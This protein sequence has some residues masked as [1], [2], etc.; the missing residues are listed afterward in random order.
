MT[1]NGG[2]SPTDPIVSV[3]QAV[4]GGGTPA[5]TVDVPVAQPGNKLRWAPDF[6]SFLDEN[7]PADAFWQDAVAP[8]AWNNDGTAA[9]WYTRPAYDPMDPFGNGAPAAQRYYAFDDAMNEGAWGPEHTGRDMPT[10][11]ELQAAGLT[12]WA[13][14][15][16]RAHLAARVGDGSDPF[17]DPAAMAKALMGL[18]SEEDPTGIGYG[19]NPFGP[20]QSGLSTGAYMAQQKSNFAYDQLME[21]GAPEEYAAAMRDAIKDYE[22]QYEKQRKEAEGDMFEPKEMFKDALGSFGQILSLPPIQAMLAAMTLGG[23]SVLAEGAKAGATAATDA[24]AASSLAAGVAPEV[25]A[26]F[27]G[28]DTAA[29][30]GADLAGAGMLGAGGAAAAPVVAGGGEVLNLFGPTSYMNQPSFLAAG[31]GEAALGA[32]GVLPP[33]A[34]VPGDVLG[35]MIKLQEVTGTSSFNEAA[36]VL[37]FDSADALMQS[38]P[39][40]APEAFSAGAAATAEPGMFDQIEK[41]Y[42]QVKP[43][44]DQYKEL[45]QTVDSLT[46]GQPADAPVR[47]EGMSDDQ[48]AAE[49]ILYMGLSPED[50]LAAGYEPGTREYNEYVLQQADRVIM[51]IMGE[52]GNTADAEQMSAALRAKSE[53]ELM[54]LQRALYVR[55]AMGQMM[56]SGKYVDPLSGNEQEVLGSGQFNPGL[57]AYGQGF[58]GDIE[59]L[60]QMGMTDA[61]GAEQFLRSILGRK[62]DMF[63]MQARRNAALEQAKMH[64]EVLDPRRKRRGM[65]S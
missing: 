3:I 8:D 30:S 63:G 64:D 14:P 17:T 45:S 48:Y 51:Q 36:Q 65:L 16:V 24:A 61:D 37:G 4:T 13:D 34:I 22:L 10:L 62:A 58:A 54:Q 57:G 40:M 43:Y 41:T 49:L 1:F 60:A 32:T 38:M 12:D 53:E 46:G 2:G 31:G 39:D 21:Q 15:T 42:D 28:L 7:D 18:W 50:I 44:V 26:L 33:H 47:G 23:S 52:V 9:G 27:S 11:A 56:G 55:G 6:T 20:Q 59:S 5:Q 29:L 19:F 35:T 25:G